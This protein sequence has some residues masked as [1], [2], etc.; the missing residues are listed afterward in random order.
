MQCNCMLVWNISLSRIRKQIHQK[1]VP[2]E[3]K[4]M[5]TSTVTSCYKSQT[6]VD[7]SQVY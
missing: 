2:R 5:E 3:V 4:H 1:S 6:F 7:Q